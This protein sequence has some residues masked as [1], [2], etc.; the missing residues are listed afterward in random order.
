MGRRKYGG[1][2]KDNKKLACYL[3]PHFK[4]DHEFGGRH[5]GNASVASAEKASTKL[6]ISS[7]CDISIFTAFQ[8]PGL[9][10]RSQETGESKTQAEEA[11][12][13]LMGKDLTSQSIS[14]ELV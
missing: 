13:V 5:G 12:C 10:P 1:K 2:E 7:N 11:L 8:G 4:S 6:H 14:R 3:K 9:D